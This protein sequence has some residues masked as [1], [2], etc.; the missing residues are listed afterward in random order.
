MLE[1]ELFEYIAG[2]MTKIRGGSPP[3]AFVPLLLVQRFQQESGITGDILEI[4]VRDG[5]FFIGLS[6]FLGEDERAL[7][8]DLFE[9]QEFNIDGS[10]ARPPDFGVPFF[11]NVASHF[12]RPEKAHSITADT[13]SL[14]ISFHPDCLQVIPPCTLFFI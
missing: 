7:A 14:S 1:K 8:I 13:L 10:G 2:P 12:N 5:K 11:E 4:G 9:A 6:F 3:E